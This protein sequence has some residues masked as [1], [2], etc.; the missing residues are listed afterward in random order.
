MGG[1]GGDGTVSEAME[2]T[3]RQTI[4]L[5]GVGIMGRGL[6]HNLLANQFK[7]LVVDSSP[8]AL[9]EAAEAGA[10]VVDSVAELAARC[11]IVITCLP[12]LSAIKSVFLGSAGLIANARPGTVLVD[13]STSDPGLTRELAAMAGAQDCPLLDAPMFKNPEAAWAGTLQ[14]IVGGDGAALEICR[15][16]LETFSEKIVH[17][18]PSGSGHTIKLINNAVT[19]CN[20]TI[21]CEALT[22]A[23]KL[24]IDFEI[25]C[26]VMAVSMAA[27]SSLPGVARRLIANDHTPQFST[28]VVKKDITLFTELAGSMGALTPLANGARDLIRLASADGYGAEHY[29][30]V[31]TVLEK[32]VGIT[33]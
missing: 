9:A 15:P 23:R 8:K 11:Q 13:C 24:D 29:T 31:A 10:E 20:A 19:V 18:G 5:V 26:G 27:S 17:A 3:V 14:L 6:A 28:D 2:A 33:R 25:L 7:L 32:A 30:R 12:S 16:A 1:H 21:L 4:G 22:V